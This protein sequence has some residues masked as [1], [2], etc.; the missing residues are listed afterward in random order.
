MKPHHTT[1]HRI[2]TSL[3]DSARNE[4]APDGAG[5][6]NSLAYSVFEFRVQVVG[7]TGY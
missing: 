2:S 7:K 5:P 6:G 4:T 3:S 1:G